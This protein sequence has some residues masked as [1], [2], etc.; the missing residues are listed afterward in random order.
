[1]PRYL[2]S[3]AVLAL[4]M[5]LSAPALADAA[6]KRVTCR[7]ET[8]KMAQ[9]IIRTRGRGGDYPV[10]DKARAKVGE[11]VWNAMLAGYEENPRVGE[12]DLAAFGY[13]VCVAGAPA[14]TK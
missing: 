7:T 9:I 5:L 12:R 2:M 4:G 10:L 8:Q 6:D 14:T 13:S 11:E 1:M 3:G